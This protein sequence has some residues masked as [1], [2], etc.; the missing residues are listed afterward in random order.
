MIR[1]LN[2]MGIILD[3]PILLILDPPFVERSQERYG[4]LQALAK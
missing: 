4:V 1:G 3:L 2:K